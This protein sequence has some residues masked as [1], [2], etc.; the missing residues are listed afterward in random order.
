MIICLVW[1]LLNPWA[2]A[3]EGTVIPGHRDFFLKSDLVVY[4]RIKAGNLLIQLLE[5]MQGS[6]D[7]IQPDEQ[8]V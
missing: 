6:L 3:L 7:C 5:S 1:W 4:Q 8:G 2:L